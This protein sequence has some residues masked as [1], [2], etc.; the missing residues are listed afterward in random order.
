MPSSRP[1]T[2]TAEGGA[3]CVRCNKA[4]AIVTGSRAFSSDSIVTKPNSAARWARMYC[5][6]RGTARGTISAGLSNDRI[7]QNVL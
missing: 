2:T 6:R 1:G 5:S 3:C 7:S 4:A